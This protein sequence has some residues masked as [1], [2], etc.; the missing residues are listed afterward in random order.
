MERV[1]LCSGACFQDLAGEICRYFNQAQH[2]IQ[3]AVCW[4]SHRE[5]FDALLDRLRTGV[6]VE[7]ILEYDTFNIRPEGLDFQTFIQKGGCLYAFR[8]PA[9][10]HHKFA[11]VDDRLLLTGSFNWTYNSNEENLLILHDPALVCGFQ[12]TFYHLKDRARR[13]FHVS[14]A[15]AKV[16]AAFPLFENTS[17]SLADLRRKVSTGTG[18]WT[19]RISALKMGSTILSE[20]VTSSHRLTSRLVNWRLIRHNLLDLL[21]KTYLC[22]PFLFSCFC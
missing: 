8:E 1:H 18:V 4:F 2:N 19:I 6:R 5:I 16:F 21:S 12:E 14:R 3:A 7:L 15:D 10:M 11:V 20:A 22:E 9:L 17:F 13:I